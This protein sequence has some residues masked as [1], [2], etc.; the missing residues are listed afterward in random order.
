VEIFRYQYDANH[1]LTNRWS[2]AKGNTSYTYDA[3]GNLLTVVHPTSPGI[4]N[5]YDALN[6]LTNTVDSLGVT[7]YTFNQAGQLLSEDGPWAN[8]TVSYTYQ[9]RLRTALNL[10][11][12]NASDWVQTYGYDSLPRLT[13]ITSQAGGFGYTYGNGSTGSPVTRITQLNLPN[14]AQIS[15]GYDSKVRL[16]STTLA[17]SGHTNLNSHTYQYNVGNQRTKQ[18]RFNSDFVDYTYD[19]IGQMKLALGKET[20]GATSRLQEQFRYAYDAAGNLTLRSNNNLGQIFTVDAVNALATASYD[21]NGVLTVAGTTTAAATG[22]TINNQSAALYADNTFARDGFGLTNGNNSF[23]AIAQDSRGRRDTNTVA[24]S[25]P[26]SAGY[27]YDLNGNLLSDGLRGFDYDD[28]NELVRVTVTNAWKSEFV[29]DGSFRQ[30]I[31]R[32]FAWQGGAWVQTNEVRYVYD[33]MV[34]IQER[35]GNNLP[36][37]SYTRGLDLSGS[38]Q[39]AGGIG[40]L[41]AMSRLSSVNPQHYYYHSDGSGNITAM[42]NAQQKLVATYLYDPFGN[43]LAATGPLAGLNPY[44]FSSKEFDA[45]SGLYAYGYRFYD[46]GLQRWINRD[47]LGERGG[48]NLYQFANNQSVGAIDPFGFSSGNFYAGANSGFKFQGG[49]DNAPPAFTIIQAPIMMEVYHPS[50]PVLTSPGDFAYVAPGYS[51]LVP[52]GQY[53]ISVQDGG[54]DPFIVAMLT[55]SAK[56][57]VEI[58][59]MQ[60]VFGLAGLFWDALAPAADSC[61]LVQGP[62]TRLALPAPSQVDYSWGALNSYREGGE[63][64]AIEHINYR[65]AFD[66]GFS[67]VSHFA[68][69][70]SAQDIK[71]FVDQAARYGDVTPQGG[72]GFKIDYDLGQ[73]VGT[74]QAGEA[75]SRL[76]VYIRGGQVQTVFTP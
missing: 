72:N 75:S 37:T 36:V 30:R 65:H 21:T 68:E 76:R 8:D 71:G 2:A 4:T 53:G 15:Y 22:V 14:G 63:M 46:P 59:A 23:T 64:T 28:E 18:T 49:V 70:T 17:N 16:T 3:A 26:L 11:Q 10:Q 74:D 25:L 33:G 6:R 24:A 9:N 1:R 73:T 54:E 57:G 12:P 51:D 50:V 5:Q 55:M 62:G 7:R 41:L 61:Y 56:A 43:T 35:D 29:Y 39:R 60:G 42:I 44:R 20:G 48:L 38:F 19:N 40:G 67:D 31:R 52:T 47:P 34:V 27:T 58:Y 13:N 66:S 69:G 45:N 32:E